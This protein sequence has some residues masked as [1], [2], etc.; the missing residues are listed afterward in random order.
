MLYVKEARPA[1]LAQ[2]H[3]IITRALISTFMIYTVP[4]QKK[5]PVASY[6]LEYLRCFLCTNLV[7]LFLLKIFFYSSSRRIL[8]ASKQKIT[9]KENATLLAY[10]SQ[11]S[12]HSS[13]PHAPW[14]EA[15]PSCEL[16]A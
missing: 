16:Y 14:R 8:V 13:L 12:L 4:M 11:Y 2:Q 5:L 1:I 7:I 10:P 15:A 6:A 9:K 3:E